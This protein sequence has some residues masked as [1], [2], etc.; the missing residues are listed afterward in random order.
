VAGYEAFGE[1]IV[2]LFLDLWILEGAPDEREV[3]ESSPLPILLDTHLLK[4]SDDQRTG[5]KTVRIVFLRDED[6]H[7]SF[8]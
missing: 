4:G 1:P 6:T 7:R 3:N 8:V 2:R 5:R